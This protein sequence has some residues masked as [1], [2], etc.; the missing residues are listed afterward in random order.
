M[1]DHWCKYCNSVNTHNCPE[2]PEGEGWYPLVV[3]NTGDGTPLPRINVK[4]ETVDNGIAGSTFLKVIRVEQEDDG[5]LT[6]VIDHW[7]QQEASVDE[8][9]EPDLWR[10]T[11][12]GRVGT[13][14]RCCG[15]ETREPVNHAVLSE[16]NSND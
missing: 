15:E 9:K 12:C 5:S 7:P 11:V 6:V 4:C 14:G 13:V 8:V 1:T 10:C 16:E 2:K 3:A